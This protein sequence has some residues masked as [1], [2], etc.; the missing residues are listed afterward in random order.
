[1]RPRS[2]RRKREYWICGAAFRHVNIRMC[3]CGGRL[4]CSNAP[5]GEQERGPF[6]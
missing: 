3:S 6:R 4:S 1:M 2:R 5:R